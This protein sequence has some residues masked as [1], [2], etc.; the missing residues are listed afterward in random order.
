M[1]RAVMDFDVRFRPCRYDGTTEKRYNPFAKESQ[2]VPRNEPLSAT[3]EEA[4]RAALQRAGAK[5]D[6]EGYCAAHFGDGGSAEVY[7]GQPINEGCTFALRGAG[8]TPTVAQLLFDVMVA[9][10][11]VIV[12][13]GV[14]IAPTTDCAKTAPPALG[15]VV[16]AGSGAEVAAALSGRFEAFQHKVL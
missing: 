14:V 4:V 3:E 11:W 7:V 2:D 6:A 12:G 9:G 8:I 13:E 1:G 10:N 15:H 16:V 5:P